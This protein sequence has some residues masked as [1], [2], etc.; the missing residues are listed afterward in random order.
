MRARRRQ[1]QRS[2]RSREDARHHTFF[3]MLGN[4]SFGDYFKEDAIKFAWDL[5]VNELKLAPDRLW[6]TVFEGD[7]E[8]SPDEDAEKCWEQVGAARTH[9]ALWP[10]RQLLADGRHRPV[11]PVL[12]DLLLPGSDIP[13]DE[14]RPAR[15][16]GLE[17]SC[18]RYIEIW[19]NVFMEFD[20]QADG[21]LQPSASAVH[22][23][24]HGPRAD[25]RG[26]PGRPVELRHR[27]LHPAAVGDRRRRHTPLRGLDVAAD[28]SMRV[29]ADH[30][31]AMTFL[32][33]DGVVPSNEWRGYVLRKIMRRA[34]RHGKQPGRHRALPASPGRRPGPRFRRGLSRVRT[35]REAIVQ[36]IRSEEER[37]DA[38]LAGGLPRLEELLDEAASRRR[39]GVR[40]MRRSGW[41]DTFGIPRDFIEDM[42]EER[43]LALDREGFERAM[44]GAARQGAREEQVRHGRSRRDDAVA[45]PDRSPAGTPDLVP[46]YEVTS[47]DTRIAE[48]LNAQRQPGRTSAAGR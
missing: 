31:R 6:F 47:I 27:P 33:A 15:C 40:P 9:P 23:H 14:E 42:I 1:A 43:K 21:A 3:E 12:G 46:G 4:F 48:L 29:V 13:C 41:Y 5:L 35:G 30:M 44:E 37:F 45:D 2:R 22:R 25:Y 10:Q 26:P 36:V 8:V 16:R 28:V 11:R 38:V 18:D 39:T 7:E 24:R 19:N 20:R 17:C 32:I 34:M